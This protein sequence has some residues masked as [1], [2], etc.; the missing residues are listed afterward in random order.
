MGRSYLREE[1][2]LQTLFLINM[3]D[4]S[5]IENFAARLTIFS[6]GCETFDA[7][8][9]HAGCFSPWKIA[10]LFLTTSILFSITIYLYGILNTV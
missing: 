5:P 2:S 9:M 7:D 1:I 6:G 4:W 10:A 8:C 3:L